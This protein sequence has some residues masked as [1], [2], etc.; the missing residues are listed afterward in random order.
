MKRAHYDEQKQTKPTSLL[1]E[2][3]CSDYMYADICA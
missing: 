3:N 2:I 1:S